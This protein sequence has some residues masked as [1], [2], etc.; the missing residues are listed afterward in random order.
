MN[1]LSTSFLLPLH[2]IHL[3]VHPPI[4]RLYTQHHNLKNKP[5]F[6][7]R[8]GKSFSSYQFQIRPRSFST[9]D[10]PPLHPFIPFPFRPF[11]F[12]FHFVSL[13][14]QYYTSSPPF[15]FHPSIFLL[16][17]I[18][19]ISFSFPSSLLHARW[20]TSVSFIPISSFLFLSSL[21]WF[22]SAVFMGGR[23]AAGQDYHIM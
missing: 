20:L 4:L 16:H 11:K 23:I 8:M 5:R 6:P 22:G 17:F 9:W 12:P 21:V 1:V 18:F 2:A 13:R 19:F 14:L 10:P 15:H 7:G 3:T